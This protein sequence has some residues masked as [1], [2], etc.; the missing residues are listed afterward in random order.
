MV[1]WGLGALA[2]LSLALARPLLAADI[3]GR[4]EASDW[5]GASVQ[6]FTLGLTQDGAQVSGTGVAYLGS[7]RDTVF[8][9]VAG[10]RVWGRD[11]RLTVVDIAG[12]AFDT[13]HFI[14][15]CF[16]DEMSGRTEGDLGARIFTGRRHE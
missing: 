16:R 7:E 9:D 8:L 12:T 14:G 2:V 10:T 13:H 15:G 4:W 5:Y 1:R 3:S 11:F 6:S